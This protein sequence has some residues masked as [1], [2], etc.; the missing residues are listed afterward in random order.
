[1]NLLETIRRNRLFNPVIQPEYLRERYTNYASRFIRVHGMEVHYRDEGNG[2]PVILL[3]GIGA[4]LHTWEHYALQFKESFRVISVDLPGFGLT[5][6]QP[7]HN[8][9][10]HA[11][12]SFLLSFTEKLKITSFYVVGN[13]MGGEIAT[14]FTQ[15]FPEKVKKLV[16]IDPSGSY[17]YHMKPFVFRLSEN[18]LGAAI[19]KYINPSILI[20]RSLDEIFYENKYLTPDIR[21][22]YKDL[23]AREIC[24]KAF[25]LRAPLFGNEGLI[26]FERVRRPTLILWGEK[27]SWLPVHLAKHFQRI[28]NSKLIVYQEV[29]HCPQEENPEIS[30]GDII[31]F[32]KS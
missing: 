17:P 15:K 7:E 22:R 24:R 2:I 14:R 12:M 20:D 5:S 18:P 27:D 8:Y 21:Q 16:V 25:I 3:H 32:L 29:G 11:L 13:S 23:S 19:G 10:M 30:G 1:M 28:P 6:A 4:S 31:R 9:S 26:H